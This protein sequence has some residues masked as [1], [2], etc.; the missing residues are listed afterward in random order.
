MDASCGESVDSM[1][2]LIDPSAYRMPDQAGDPGHVDSL[3]DAF[4]AAWMGPGVAK[5]RSALP[6]PDVLRSMDASS[7]SMHAHHHGAHAS[8]HGAGVCVTS[9]GMAITH[10]HAMSPSPPRG[11]GMAAAA[12]AADAAATAST[13]NGRGGGT[14]GAPPSAGPSGNGNGSGS[15]S[16]VIGGG[17]RQDGLRGFR[18]AEEEA[19]ARLPMTPPPAHAPISAAKKAALA[20]P[21]ARHT[22]QAVPAPASGAQPTAHGVKLATKSEF[23]SVFF[24][25]I[26]TNFLG[27]PRS[28]SNDSFMGGA[29]LGSPDMTLRGGRLATLS[30]ANGE[31]QE[32]E[33]DA[34][35]PSAAVSALRQHGAG[36]KDTPS[37]PG[38]A[39][40]PSITEGPAGDVR[41]HAV[42]LHDSSVGSGSSSGT[43][44]TSTGMHTGMHTQGDAPLQPISL[45]PQVQIGMLH[46][47]G[48]DG[49]GLLSSNGAGMPMHGGISIAAVAAANRGRSKWGNLRL[50][51]GTAMIP[52]IDKVE[53]GG[54]DAFCICLKGFGS[55]GVADGVSGWA[56]EGIDPAEYSRSLM[57]FSSI[58]LE[59][60]THPHGADPREVIRHAHQE[61]VMPGSSTICVC[62]MK[63]GGKMSVANLG[64]SG[65]RLI[66]DG[67]IVFASTAQQ[68]MFNMPFQLSHPSI[69]ESPDDADCAEVTVHDMQPGDVV[70]LAT[71]GLYDNVFD[72]EIASI[73]ADALRTRMAVRRGEGDSRG[74]GFL[75]SEDAEHVAMAIAHTAHS[76]A[77]NPYKRTPW[78]VSAAE[79]G[80]PWARYFVKGGGKMDDITVVIGFITEEEKA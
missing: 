40:M 57:K 53:K 59:G 54:E 52:H 43:T 65:V 72:D 9:T 62:V 61:T 29:S 79:T 80:M 28:E 19:F 48:S 6:G 47:L 58:A 8:M 18:D 13:S 77:Q 63:P 67:R 69:I 38:A 64:D 56:E 68:H 75:T 51:A 2:G 74:S 78:S 46:A 44:T 33:Q 20:A 3:M 16:Q 25:P 39:T 66:R 37:R 71:D 41:S 70:V 76:Y 7:S 1:G 55:I 4:D 30:T 17:R 12:A 11:T 60:T 36:K 27:I 26:P 21:I 22:A 14:N 35:S 24:S 49:P 5:G 73:V 32:P 42:P 15:S 45:G 23:S 31:W 50:I 34:S 10:G